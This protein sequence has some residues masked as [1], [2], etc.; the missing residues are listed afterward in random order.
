M[1]ENHWFQW[2]YQINVSMSSLSILTVFRPIK[3]TGAISWICI[4]TAIYEGLIGIKTNREKKNITFWWFGIRQL[5]EYPLIRWNCMENTRFNGRNLSPKSTNVIF[6]NQLIRKRTKFR[7]SE[8]QKKT[9]AMK[10]MNKNTF[11]VMC[12]VGSPNAN[13]AKIEGLGCSN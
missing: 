5:T 2:H 9:T 7:L 11:H 13:R 6:S 8:E 10:R 4:N 12:H 1:I 3:N